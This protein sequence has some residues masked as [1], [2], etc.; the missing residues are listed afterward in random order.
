M[1]TPYLGAEPA[2]SIENPDYLRGSR[3]AA[4]L[5]AEEEPSSG[6]VSAPVEETPAHPHQF[7][8][9]AD[10]RA[11]LN[12]GAEDTDDDV[13][14]IR[15]YPF[16]TPAPESAF[17]VI[18]VGV[19]ANRGE[20]ISDRKKYV[21]S[22]GSSPSRYLELI[23]AHQLVKE[24]NND[25]RVY[26]SKDTIRDLLDQEGCIGL[27]IYADTWKLTPEELASPRV[28]SFKLKDEQTEFSTLTITGVG[29]DM[30]DLQG[31]NYYLSDMPCPPDCGD[32]PDYR[33]RTFLNKYA[34]WD[35][36]DEPLSD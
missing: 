25:Y 14:G 1:E 19:L 8:N 24:H 3:I 33:Y 9:A 18:A 32:D 15:F 31:G 21:L 16:T 34:D 17:K 7:F 5:S 26:F 30:R 4:P 13:V 36:S 11:I 6:D 2:K 29:L 22:E 35:H 28:L 10:L 20:V 12:L 27:R 23:G